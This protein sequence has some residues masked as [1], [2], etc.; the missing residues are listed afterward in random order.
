MAPQTKAGRATY[1]RSV[2]P[3]AGGIFDAHIQKASVIGDELF[4]QL[5]GLAR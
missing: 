3:L 4:T 5:V 1:Q 2:H